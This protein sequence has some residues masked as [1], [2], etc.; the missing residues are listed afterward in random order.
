MCGIGNDKSMINI[1]IA[2]WWLCAALAGEMSTAEDLAS[3][4]ER[5]NE[6][7][8]DKVDDDDVLHVFRARYLEKRVNK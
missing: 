3:A 1:F 4:A 7:V 6:T 5:M 2:D 8:N